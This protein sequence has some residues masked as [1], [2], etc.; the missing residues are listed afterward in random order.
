MC[1]IKAELRVR[2]EAQM[3]QSFNGLNSREVMNHLLIA[4]YE[5]IILY[6]A[7]VDQFS[8]GILLWRIVSPWASGRAKSRPE[9]D[10]SALI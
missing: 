10:G 2:L 7:F 9:V 3:I 4:G 5:R 8:D 6:G 1:G